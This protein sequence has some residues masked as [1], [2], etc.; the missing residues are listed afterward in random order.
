MALLVATTTMLLS[1]M[2]EKTGDKAVDC[3]KIIFC[4]NLFPGSSESAE[5][6]PDLNGITNH[7]DRGYTIHST[8]FNFLL[9]AGA[10]FT[11]TVKRIM[12]FPFVWGMKLNRNDPS[13]NLDEKGA[14]TLYIREVMSHGRLVTCSAFRTGTGNVSA[15]LTT[16]IHG[17]QWE[18][19]CLHA[20]ERFLYEDDNEHGLDKLIFPALATF[21]NEYDLHKDEVEDLLREIKDEKVDVLTLEQGT[22]DW[23]YGRKFSLTS[24][25]ASRSFQVAFI[26]YQMNDDWVQVARNLFGDEYY[27]RKLF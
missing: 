5:A 7:S 2:F 27:E 19:I 11:N 9:P 15:V 22:A 14:P 1:F 8:I 16:K 24:S 17:H 26:N 18:G 23:H 4:K 12:P 10:D 13:K 21:K 3:L 25:Q 6:L 20:S